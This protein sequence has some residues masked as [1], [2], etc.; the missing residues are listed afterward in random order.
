MPKFQEVEPR[1]LIIKVAEELKKN[2]VIKAPAWTI[3]A[4]TGAHAA[5]PPID[6]DWWYSRAASLLRKIAI[7]G[8]VGTEK[9][10]TIYGGRKR[11]GHQPAEFRPAGGSAIRKVLQQLEKAGYV[12]YKDKG[13]KKGRILTPLGISFLDKVAKEVQ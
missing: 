6:P 9:L 4:K 5:R 12:K 13:I 2:S 8:P 7:R 10:R 1:K 3:F 11:R